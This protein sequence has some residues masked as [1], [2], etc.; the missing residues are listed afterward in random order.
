VK[1][2]VLIADDEKNMRWVL[3]ESLTASGY[4][5]FEAANG[6]EAL[7]AIEEQMPDLLVL[8]HKMP[9]PDG[10]E[11]LRRVR[12]K[13]MPFP[14]I[15]L[16]AHGNVETAVEAM[17]AGATEYI[18]K[19]FDLEELKIRIEHAVAV[20]DL[21]A[22]VV[23]LREELDRDYDI[24]GIVAADAGMLE[25]LGTIRTVAPT[26]ASVLLFGES[27]TGK[28]L[29]ARAIHKLS[30]RGNKPFVSVSAGALPETLLESELFGYEKGAFTGAIQAKPGRFEMANGGTLFLDEVGDLT[31]A[32]Q[33]KLLRVLQ[34]R[35]F[36]RLGGTRTIE[37]DVRIVTATNRDLQQMIADGEFR[38]D[39]YYRLNVVPITLPPLR[40][41]AGDIPRLVAHFMEKFKAGD[42]QITPEAM[43]L[44]SEYQWPGNIRE[45][46][47]AIERIVI[48][49]KSDR[50]DVGDLPAEVRAGLRAPA[51]GRHGSRG[52]RARP[53]PAGARSR[54]RERSEGG[55]APRTDHEDPRGTHEAL[56][57]V[58][59]AAR[60]PL[61]H[62]LHLGGKVDGPCLER[63]WTRGASR[64]LR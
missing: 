61:A 20:G 31:P 18:T 64:A 17:K 53:R 62:R 45:L 30:P 8:D 39:L 7:A 1:K 63:A 59:S 23:R 28:E 40:Q 29:A 13:G 44:L 16:T 14:V 22:E 35:T 51:R 55:E 33:V 3:A 41:R 2:R 32:V 4:E 11:V 43:R 49:S 42:K 56:G 26:T 10:M 60:G 47:N 19:P 25:V 6:T 9:A 24:E 37:V 50:M 38:E 48:L 34:E 58:G 46:E 12:G 54:G 36:E 52:G 27:G 57:S 15:M 21:A 5:V